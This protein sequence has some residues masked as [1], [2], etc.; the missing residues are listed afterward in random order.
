[1]VATDA[2]RQAIAKLRQVLAIRPIQV[3]ARNGLEGASEQSRRSGIAKLRQ[4]LVLRICLVDVAEGRTSCLELVPGLQ[5]SVQSGSGS[6]LVR[7]GAGSHSKCR[8]ALCRIK[9][10]FASSPD[11]SDLAVSVETLWLRA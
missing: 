10:P 8:P 2:D 1:M 11:R 9:N 5:Q 6:R 3:P 7:S 4:V